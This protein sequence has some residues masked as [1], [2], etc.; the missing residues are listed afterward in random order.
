MTFLLHAYEESTKVIQQRRL[1][2]SV[3]IPFEETSIDWQ[4]V[5]SQAMSVSSL[6]WWARRLDWWENNAVLVQNMQD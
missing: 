3:C 6:D 2:T 4:L 5:S 1:A